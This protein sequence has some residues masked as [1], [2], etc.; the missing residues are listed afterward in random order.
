[1]KSRTRAEG[2]EA[3]S[4][5]PE[6]FGEVIRRDVQKWR[7]VMKEAKLKRED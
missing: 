7:R 4:G 6:E 2:L 5:S 1:L 3:A